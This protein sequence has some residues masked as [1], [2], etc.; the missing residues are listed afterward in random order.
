[1]SGVCC[2]AICLLDVEN[3]VYHVLLVE[4][5]VQVKL[6]FGVTTK[7]RYGNAGEVLAD[8]EHADDIADKLKLLDEVRAPDTVGGVEQEDDVGRYTALTHS[9]YNTGIKIRTSAQSSHPQARLT[10]PS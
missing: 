7:R 8:L 10:K 1:M 5:I 9:L 3:G 6:I 2:L 4:I